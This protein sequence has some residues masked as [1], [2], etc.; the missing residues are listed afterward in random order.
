MSAFTGQA[1][2]N[3]FVLGGCTG[4]GRPEEV[5]GKGRRVSPNS[6]ICVLRS[7]AG[8]EEET[9]RRESSRRTAFPFCEFCQRVLLFNLYSSPWNCWP[10]RPTNRLIASSY[11]RGDS[12]RFRYRRAALSRFPAPPPRHVVGGTAIRV[13]VIR[14]VYRAGGWCNGYRRPS[15]LQ[16]I[17]A[18]IIVVITNV[19]CS[20]ELFELCDWWNF[21]LKNL[22][23]RLQ[24]WLYFR[25]EWIFWFF[26]EF[27]IMHAC[28]GF[29]Q[30]VLP[31]ISNY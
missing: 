20:I 11:A 24:L 5:N 3:T 10:R 29:L 6:T 9:F 8:I 7:T 26:S 16:V 27:K 22:F 17:T 12:R 19:R 2:R 25:P 4:S 18:N 14:P 30:N 23:Y 1:T 15:T 31:Q 13:S 28:F 21:G